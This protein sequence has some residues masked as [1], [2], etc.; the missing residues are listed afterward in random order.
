[1]ITSNNQRGEINFSNS[2]A[3]IPTYLFT[4]TFQYSN[5]IPIR[6]LILNA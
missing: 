3:L 5:K 4:S 2:K 6:R 1:M